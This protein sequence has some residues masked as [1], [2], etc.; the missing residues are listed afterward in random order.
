MN[1][2]FLILVFLLAAL[3]VSIPLFADNTLTLATLDWQPYAGSTLQDRGASVAVATAA[4]KAMGYDLKVEFYPWERTVA[5]AKT[6]PAIAGYFPEYYSDDGAQAFTFSDPMG[7]GPLGFAESKDDPVKWTQLSDLKGVPIGVVEGYVNTAEFDSMVAQK[8]LKA[9]A[10][11]DDKS[12]LAKLINKRIRLAVID[13]YVMAYLLQTDPALA[14]GRNKLQFN[15]KILESKKLYVCFKKGPEGKKMADVFN[16]GLKKI[17]VAQIMN[18]YFA[19][20]FK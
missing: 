7:E 1:K 13:K 10:V 3:S 15:S 9:D 20:A 19:K 11:E 16:Q 4:F 5:K 18:A 6:D 17:D 14:S 12:N 8:A 2:R